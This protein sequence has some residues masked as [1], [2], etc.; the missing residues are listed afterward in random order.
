MASAVDSGAKSQ[1]VSMK[2]VRK[3]YALQAA[4][5]VRVSN[6]GIKKRLGT[7]F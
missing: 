1:R 5:K 3:M 2:K 6:Q 4:T 7:D